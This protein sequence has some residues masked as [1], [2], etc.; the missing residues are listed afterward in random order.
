MAS[1][2]RI[3][4]TSKRNF[5]EFYRWCEK[6]SEICKKE[7]QKDLLKYF[8]TSPETFNT[9]FTNYAFGVPI[10]CFPESLDKWLMKHCPIIWIR[11]SINKQYGGQYPIKK[12]EIA[13]YIDYGKEP[14][15]SY[16]KT[17]SNR[18]I[19]LS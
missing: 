7:T 11:D 18:I 12:K 19:K 3:Y 1:I 13:L 2:D 14:K 17:P 15:D 4:C 6:F 10:T 8:Y 5:I 16:Q 9:D